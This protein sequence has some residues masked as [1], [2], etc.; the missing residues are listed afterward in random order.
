MLESKNSN[1]RQ[2]KQ[3]KVLLKNVSSL[4]ALSASCA[5]EWFFVPR[6]WSAAGSPRSRLTFQEILYM[7]SSKCAQ[8]RKL[9]KKDRE[10]GVHKVRKMQV[11]GMA[12]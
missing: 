8:A 4:F 7:E 1:E 6:D 2:G 11:L 12:C 3:C 9:S 10:F 5:S